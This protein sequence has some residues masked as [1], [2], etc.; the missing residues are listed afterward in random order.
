MKPIL[1]AGLVC[2]DQVTVVTTFP[3]EDTDQ[4][5]VAQYKSRGGNANNSCTVLAHLGLS[6][7]Y[8]GTFARCE[9]TEWLR[10]GLLEDGVEV[11]ECPEHS[12]YV[13]PNSVVLS[14]TTTGSRTIIH[15]NLGLPE[16]SL[17]DFK[18]I[19]LADFR[20]E[21]LSC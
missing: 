11:G 10:Q 3:V 21:V 9:D 4:R 15:T 14:N 20:W 2:L 16:L 1:C 13:C 12:G 17:Q 7:T 8:L 6:S 19:N 5:S 18:N